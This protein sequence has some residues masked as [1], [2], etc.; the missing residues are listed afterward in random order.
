MQ[1]EREEGMRNEKLAFLKFLSFFWV[2][3]FFSVSAECRRDQIIRVEGEKARERETKGSPVFFNFFNREERTSLFV[4][5]FLFF[6]K[7]R[8]GQIWYFRNL[9]VRFK[10]MFFSRAFIARD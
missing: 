4:F 1:R 10:G 8:R 7:E 3:F 5:F 6:F 2:F 9:K